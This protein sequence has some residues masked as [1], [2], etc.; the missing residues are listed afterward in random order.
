MDKKGTAIPIKFWAGLQ[1]EIERW[2]SEHGG[3]PF[4][5]AVNQLC[6]L[7]LFHSSYK[8]PFHKP[9][10]STTS[11]NEEEENGI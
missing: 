11:L 9:K 4:S 3:I 1:D 5:L 7:A 8:F 2:A 6:D 10:Y